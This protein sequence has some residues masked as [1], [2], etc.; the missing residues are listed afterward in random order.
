LANDSSSEIKVLVCQGLITL[1]EVRLDYVQRYLPAFIDCMLVMTRD[2]DETVALEATEFWPVIA[3]TRMCNDILRANLGRILPTLL[4]GMVYSD[5]EIADFDAEEEDENVPDKPQ[6]IKPFVYSKRG[7]DDDDDGDDDY[8]PED[9]SLRKCSAAGLDIFASEFGEEILP[10]V[11]PIISS[12]LQSVDTEVWAQK[13]SAILALGAVAEGCGSGIEKFLP[14]I[15]PFLLQQGGHPKVRCCSSCHVCCM[16]ARN[17]TDA[18]S[19]P[20]SVASG[21][22]YHVLVAVPIWRMDFG[23]A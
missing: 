9:W 21:Q 1:V 3:E 22:K 16:F 18:L 10:I 5:S 23:A 2:D 7:G 12:R 19:F 17:L 6:D 20:L 15:I 4:D 14:E 11:L 13:E 8:E